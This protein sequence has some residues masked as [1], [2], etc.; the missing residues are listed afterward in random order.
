[1]KRIDWKENNTIQVEPVKKP[2]KITG[3]RLASILGLNKWNSAFKT[4]CEITR[5]Y[6]EPF[7][8]NQYTLAGKT[9]EPVLIDLLKQRYFMD[10]KTPSDVYGEDY[11]KK[12]FGDFYHNNNIF[13]GMW[14]AIGENTIVEI[15]TTKRVEDWV[16]DTPEYYKIQAALYAWLS[17]V[18]NIIFVCAF[19]DESDYEKPEYFKPVVGENVIIREYKLKEMYSDF[20]EDI[21]VPAVEFWSNHVETG[22]SPAYGKADEEIIKAL[23]RDT[24]DVNEDIS[25]VLSRIDE[26]KAKIEELS[27]ELDPLEKEL[28][29]K[30]EQ[31]KDYLKEQFTD[32]VDKLDLK[33]GSYCFTLSKTSTS[34]VDTKLLKADGI[35]EKYA[36]QSVSYRLTNKKL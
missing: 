1:M 12:T 5:T 25:S 18:E 23:R 31:L 4:W 34:K 35:F 13:G 26:L 3:T 30:E 20:Y 36:I 10:I 28:K 29:A 15:K 8:D 22:I 6:E 17:G 14:D 16:E 11:F 32:G 24:V 27:V 33:S 7:I 21:I 9:I 19:L 2:K